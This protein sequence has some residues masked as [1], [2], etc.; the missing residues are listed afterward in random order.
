[1]KI[2]C[3]TVIFVLFL[4]SSVFAGEKSLRLE[5]KPWKSTIVLYEPFWFTV[6][7]ENTG[8]ARVGVTLHAWMEFNGQS[9]E[10]VPNTGETSLLRLWFP[11][12]PRQSRTLEEYIHSNAKVPALCVDEDTRY[13]ELRHASEYP[14]CWT[15]HAFFKT[16]HYRFWLGADSPNGPVT[17]SNTIEV[18]VVEPYGQDAQAVLKYEPTGI[19]LAMGRNALDDHRIEI[20]SPDFSK[21]PFGNQQALRS[22][23]LSA[24]PDS[25]Y[26][27][28]VAT[29]LC[30]GEMVGRPI[31]MINAKATDKEIQATV[32]PGFEACSD[33]LSQYGKVAHPVVAQ[34][35]LLYMI[36]AQN[37]LGNAKKTEGLMQKFERDYPAAMPG[38]SFNFDLI[39]K[40]IKQKKFDG[41]VRGLRW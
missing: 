36:M 5:I 8:D 24:F 27:P 14:G 29:A 25:V 31:H 34:H 39:R 18:T 22:E 30:R 28:Y 26:A 1:M 10:V 21:D 37:K 9:F 12:E 35:L 38:Q 17:V 7:L 2:K 13:H 3:V 4:M 40:N 16:G 33:A 32:E 15:H 19:S 6:S 20:I 11:M 41:D 23:F